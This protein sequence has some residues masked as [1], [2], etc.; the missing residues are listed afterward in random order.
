MK[1]HGVEH[2]EVRVTATKEG[3]CVIL[4]PADLDSR[5]VFSVILEDLDRL[6]TLHFGGAVYQTPRIKDRLIGLYLFA[7]GTRELMRDGPISYTGYPGSRPLYLNVTEVAGA[8]RQDLLNFGYFSG[9]LIIQADS[10]IEAVHVAAASSCKVCGGSLSLFGELEWK[11]CAKCAAVC[12][13]EYE[14]G[15]GQAAGR[16]S[17]MTFCAKCGRGA[18]SWKSS[19]NPHEDL[20][21]APMGA[22]D[23]SDDLHPAKTEAGPV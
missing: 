18:P 16:L 19:D 4:T 9:G 15:L 13:H 11:T 2:S 20:E 22:P 8:A 7:G 23:A 5:A 12:A 14:K 17:Y 3:P 6:S 21:G 1:L 10:T